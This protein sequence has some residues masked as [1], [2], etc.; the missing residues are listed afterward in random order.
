MGFILT[1]W[2][3]KKEVMSSFSFETYGFILTKWYV[4]YNLLAC[5]N[6]SN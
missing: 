2:Y 1:K 6:N 4:K 3:V 5:F